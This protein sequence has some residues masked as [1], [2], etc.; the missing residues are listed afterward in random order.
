MCD[1]VVATAQATADGVTLLGKNSDRDPNEAHHLL[2]VPAADHPADSRVSCTYLSI[3][4]QAHTYAL[5]LAKPFWIW[6]AEM[7]VNE[8]GVAIGNEAVFTKVPYGREKGLI[9]MDLLRLA[10][11]RAATAGEAV[12]VITD[13][14]ARYGQGGNCGFQSKLRYHNSFLIADPHTAWVLETAGPHWA[15]REVQGVYT[16]SNV[17]TIGREWDLASPDLVHYAVQ[18]SWCK[19]RDDFH[20]SRC[21]SDRLYTW[22][23][24]GRHR[25]SR[26]MERLIS[27]QGRLTPATV[28]ATLRDHG[29]ERETP[30]RPERGLVGAEVC[31]HAA[32]GPA[33]GSQTTG[34]MVCHLHAAHPTHWFTATAAPCT[35]V[36]KPLWIDAPLPDT[37]PAPKGTYDA[38]TLYW[39]H[40]ALHRATLRDYALLGLYQAERDELERAFVDQ[41]SAIASRPAAERAAF[42]AGCLAQAD[43]AEAR[44]LER[45]SHAQ[46]DRR[47]SWL[48]ALAWNKRNR[49][50][51]MPL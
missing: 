1:T 27:Q 19:S 51:Q 28:M 35:S 20:F 17:L 46:V 40:E 30:W 31:A 43:A 37:G 9:G 44:W 5:L 15:A 33:R 32:F 36:F 13:L 48:Y 41:A 10:L 25:R 26:T 49:Q 12:T 34:S 21:Y 38:A 8:R 22:L 42:A 4:Q 23:A 16:I 18:R 29:G 3:P 24:Y 47:R 14:L 7:G 50:A 39:R 2:Y 45:V 11:E 6:G